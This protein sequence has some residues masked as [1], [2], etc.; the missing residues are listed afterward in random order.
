[1]KLSLQDNVTSTQ[2]LK[3]VI[4]EVRKY[5]KWFNQ[6]S[7]K[8]RT[9]KGS[10]YQ[11]PAISPPAANLINE[12]V[13]GKQVSQEKL[14][15]LTAVLEDFEATA[16]RVSIALAAPPPSDLRQTLT[17]WF[18]KN[19]DPNTLV[20]FSFNAT[21]LGGMVVQYGSHVYDWSFKRQILAAREHFPEVLRHV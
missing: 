8:M 16:P 10:S 3:A 12:C 20:D 2:D 15:E 9:T 21:M 1:M 17:G 18:R 7:V 11:P 6:T 13:E 19:I 14:D 5:A 4:L